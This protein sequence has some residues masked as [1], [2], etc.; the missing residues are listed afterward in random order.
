MILCFFPRIEVYAD[1]IG[2]GRCY[3]EGVYF[4]DDLAYKIMLLKNCEDAPYVGLFGLPRIKK[5]QRH[6]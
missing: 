6:L 5:H 4:L 2:P 3:Q 1:E